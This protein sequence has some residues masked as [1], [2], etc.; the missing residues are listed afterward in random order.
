[1]LLEK[2]SIVIAVYNKCIIQLRYLQTLNNISAEKNS[3]VIFPG[4][5]LSVIFP[6]REQYSN[7]PR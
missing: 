7:I 3:T 5:E 6:G 4:R 1:M 2:I